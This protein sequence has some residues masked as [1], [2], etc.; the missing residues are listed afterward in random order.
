ML[1]NLRGV[2]ATADD[3]VRTLGAAERLRLVGK[4]QPAAS[5]EAEQ[6]DCAV[7]ACPRISA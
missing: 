2:H 5:T 4:A 3:L 7:Q 6:L 1:R